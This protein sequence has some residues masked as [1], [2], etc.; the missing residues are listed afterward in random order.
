MSMVHKHSFSSFV[1]FFSIVTMPFDE[2]YM[3]EGPLST[4][5]RNAIAWRFAG[6]P[7][8]GHMFMLT[9]LLLH[10]IISG[11]HSSNI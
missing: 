11:F 9:G 1:A 6:G 4:H 7:L 10:L 3:T 5:K 2:K 8:V